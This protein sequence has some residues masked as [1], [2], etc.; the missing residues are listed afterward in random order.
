MI[1]EMKS[2]SDGLIIRLD[3]AEGTHTDDEERTTEII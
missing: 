3:T 1:S 2:C